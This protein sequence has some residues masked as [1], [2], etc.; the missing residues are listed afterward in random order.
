VAPRGDESEAYAK[1]AVV[2]GA[3]GAARLA[4]AR[5]ARFVLLLRDPAASGGI[6]VQR[7]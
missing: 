5:D 6:A 1:A 7:F 3:E 4:A 2:L